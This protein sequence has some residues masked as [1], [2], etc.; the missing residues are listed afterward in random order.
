MKNFYIY[1]HKK[2]TNLEPFYIGKG[3]KNRAYVKSG[4]SKYWKNIVN[5][6]DYIIEFLE[7]NLTEFES[8]EKEIYWINKFGRKNINNGLLCNLTN[9]GEG[10]SGKIV[11]ENVKLAVSKSNKER[12]FSEHHKNVIKNRY[13][14]KFG[15]E[16][17]RSKNIICIETNIEYESMSQAAKELNISV[18]SV[19]WSVKHKKP[20]FGMHFEIKE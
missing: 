10:T 11:K 15:S 14:N 18:S 16:H 12:K 6:H 7:I 3:S 9:G 4:R 17:N 8:L 1:I 13:K 5:K 2:A 20:I 19:S